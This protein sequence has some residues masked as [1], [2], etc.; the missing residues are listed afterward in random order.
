MFTIPYTYENEDER[1][2]TIPALRRFAKEKRN[3]DLRTNI[4]RAQLFHELKTYANQS[5]EKKEEVKEWL[6]HVLIEGIKEV[7]IKYLDMSTLNY[8]L[9]DTEYLTSVFEPLLAEPENRHLCGKYTQDLQIYKYEIMDTEQGRCI[10]VYMGKLL[11]THDKRN[12]A[13]TVPYP[14]HVEFF[15]DLGIIVSRAKSKSGLYK[16][17]EDF[18]LN[19]AEATKAE[20]EMKTAIKYLCKLLQIKVADGWEVE[21]KLKK[22]L[23][24]MLEQ[25]TA[26]PREIVELIE[27]KSTHI[28]NLLEY[29]MKDICNLPASYRDDVNSN[30]LNMVEKYFSI[31]YP[32]KKIF[33]QDREAYPLKLNATD[34][35]ESKV[36]QTAALEEPLQAK[37]I[38][39]DNKKMLQKSQACDGVEFMFNR[40]NSLY[41]T[42]QFKV[43]FIINT[44]TCI[45]R[46]TEYTMEEDIKNVIFSF[47]GLKR[48]LK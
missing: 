34:E 9:Y 40:L 23:Y 41:C 3:E 27:A 46:F 43:K 28:E 39:F 18:D 1:Y 12:G 32:D 20:K 4:D 10:G 6:D 7:Q 33:T 47:I 2:I 37:A 42:K 26:T 17:M 11:C 21:N 15:L 30:I 5:E 14:I 22:L 29:M 35:E 44:E 45:L 38:F 16:Y 19:K 25:Y 13:A 31:S 48:N 8:F 24:E 36:E